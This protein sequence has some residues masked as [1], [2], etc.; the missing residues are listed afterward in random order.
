VQRPK[1]LLITGATSAIGSALAVAYAAP[2][3][4]LYL[5]GRNAAGLADVSEKCRN[6]GAVIHSYVCDVRDTKNMS[7]WLQSL[8]SIDLVIINAGTNTAI[9]LA[10][11]L[12]PWDDVE[13][14]LD[15]NLKAAIAAVHAVLPTMR[16]RGRGQIALMSSLAGYY[17]IPVTPTYSASKAGL[18]AYGEALRALLA[19]EGIMVN[20]IMPGYVESPMCRAMPGSKPGLWTPERA[21]TVIQRHLAG[22]RA[23][24]SFPFPLNVGTWFLAVTPAWLSQ[25]LISWFGPK[26]GQ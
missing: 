18:K 24:I 12:E 3:V 5:H 1:R 6:T 25:R 26:H 15:V 9:S 8:E 7:A 4:T 19:P 13:A 23:R 17:G 10:G 2:G 14:V 20:V 11:E 21:A 16:R 22:N